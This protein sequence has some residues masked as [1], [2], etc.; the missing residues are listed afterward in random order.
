MQ[1]TNDVKVQ[2]SLVF[3]TSNVKKKGLCLTER[4]VTVKIRVMDV[5]AEVMVLLSPIHPRSLSALG[6]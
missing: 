3:L 4:T 5:S 1:L 6:S 2:S